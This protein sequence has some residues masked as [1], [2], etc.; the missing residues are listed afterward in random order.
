M[1]TVGMRNRKPAHPD[2]SSTA[3]L[4]TTR[5][6]CS[7]ANNDT[8]FVQPRWTGL[9]CQATALQQLA[10]CQA[11]RIDIIETMPENMAYT[12]GQNN[13]KWRI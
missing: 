13:P 4:I 5:A 7:W 8:A 11:A 12:P 6:N 9:Y 3:T 1:I 2:S 10:H